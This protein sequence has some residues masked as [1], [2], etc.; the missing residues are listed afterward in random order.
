MNMMWSRLKSLT[1][2]KCLNLHTWR[3]DLKVEKLCSLCMKQSVNQWHFLLPQTHRLPPLKT[4]S[5]SETKPC[6]VSVYQSVFMHNETDDL[7]LSTHFWPTRLKSELLSFPPTNRRPLTFRP[8]KNQ[9][10]PT[11]WIQTCSRSN[12]ANKIIKTLTQAGHIYKFPRS[13]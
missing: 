6:G 3:S 10:N 5:H 11:N 8:L 7:T 4:Q 9:W 12:S 1:V 13:E 2:K